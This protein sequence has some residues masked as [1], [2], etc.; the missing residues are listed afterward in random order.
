MRNVDDTLP[1]R[2]YQCA[3]TL[4]ANAQAAQWQGPDP[5]DGLYWKWP[6]AMTAT[7]LRRQVVAQL[8][9]RSPVDIRLGRRSMPQLAKTVA[10]FTRAA[11]QAHRFSSDPTLLAAGRNAAEALCDDRRA[12]EYAWGYPFAVQTRW[13]GYPAHSPNVVVTSFAIDALTVAANDLGAPAYEDRARGAAEWISDRLFRPA[14]YFAY[15][16][17]SDVLVHN[18]N[19]LGAAAV[20]RLFPDS[21]LVRI[22]V[23]RSL[24]A[25]QADGS[26]PY[27]EGSLT[28]IDNFHTAY[29][30]SCL[31]RMR[32]LGLPS[33]D[34][35]IK[36]GME[37]WL[38]SFFDDRGRAL[39]WPDKPFPEDG[40]STGTSLSAFAIMLREGLADPSTV[41]RIGTRA[42]DAMV[43]RGR[44]VHRRY[45]WGRTNVRYLRWC[46]GHIAMG[47]SAVALAL[48]ECQSR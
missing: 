5:Y 36:R 12:G 23:E 6:A 42:I 38:Q 18:A 26:W 44:T 46:D 8:H 25:Q 17:H 39:L 13:S 34:E 43:V 48:R 1:T 41:E 29:V 31:C 27:G 2:L 40:H 4:I 21:P 19:L 32:D 24:S 11:I 9:A 10:L 35:A 3:A 14:G 7:P 47:A 15:H 33:L 30:L 16:E 22:A 37:Y 45:R 28:F 20:H